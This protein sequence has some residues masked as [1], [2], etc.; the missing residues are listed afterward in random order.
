MPPVS[1]QTGLSSFLPFDTN[2]KFRKRVLDERLAQARIICKLVKYK[3]M[4]GYHV[5]E[6]G[7][8]VEY[9][10]FVE[11]LIAHCSP[12]YVHFNLQVIQS[13]NS[14]TAPNEGT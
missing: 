13:I 10:Y 12:E 8:G 7:S 5:S 11:V 6:D 1:R 14:T 4:H 3:Q 2:K 9:P